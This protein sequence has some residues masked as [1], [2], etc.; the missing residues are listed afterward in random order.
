METYNLAELI[1]FVI[2]I[3]DKPSEY[4]DLK[5]RQVI[6]KTGEIITL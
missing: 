2:E 5:P 6:S 4:P 3:R 1:E